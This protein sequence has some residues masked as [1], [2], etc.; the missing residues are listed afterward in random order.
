M[1]FLVKL[2]RCFS[3]YILF[4]L[5]SFLCSY[6]ELHSCV[7][8]SFFSFDDLGFFLQLPDIFLAV[9]LKLPRLIR[10]IILP[11]QVQFFN[12]GFFGCLKF[13]EIDS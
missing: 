13:V 3:G 6:S 12:L 1:P 11:D 8:L 2:L 7:F 10:Q 4:F 9:F 5:K